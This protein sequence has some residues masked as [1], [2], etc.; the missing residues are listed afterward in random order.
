MCAAVHTASSK[1]GML[2]L[3]GAAGLVSADAPVVSASLGRC[4]GVW[5]Y[6]EVRQID[7]RICEITS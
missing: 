1:Q 3:K 4:L 5:I 2:Q 6:D 7:I